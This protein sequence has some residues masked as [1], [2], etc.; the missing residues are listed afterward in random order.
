MSTPVYVFASLVFTAFQ[1]S[2]NPYF[3]FGI[4]RL[5]AQLVGLFPLLVLGRNLE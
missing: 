4:S 1:Y 2:R 3:F 5:P